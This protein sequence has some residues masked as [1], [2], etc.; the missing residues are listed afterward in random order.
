[1]SAVKEKSGAT[2]IPVRYRLE[3]VALRTFLSL[4]RL[5]P[6]RPGRLLAR[7]LG[8]LLYALGGRRRALALRNI[9]AAS[10]H[11]WSR[12]PRTVARAN[13]IHLAYNLFEF[14]RMGNRTEGFFRSRV[15]FVGEE[16]VREAFSKGRGVLFL[17]AHMGNWEMMGAAY[18]ALKG[19]IHV[20]ARPMQ[21]PLTDALIN[22]IRRSSGMEVIPSRGA[23]WRV[24]RALRRGEAVGVLLD[25]NTLRRE[26]VFVDFLGRP[27]ATNYGLAALA[28]KTGSPVLPVYSIRDGRGRH[29]VVFMPGIPTE[30]TDDAGRDILENTARYSA[31]IENMVSSCPAQW[32]WVH[33]RW[34][35]QPLNTAEVKR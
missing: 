18:A 20:V 7:M 29:R 27:A 3:Y 11:S 25:Q 35:N 28:R 12:T 16:H 10:R 33:N 17:T 13:F 34:K 6:E 9:A 22:G 2:A 30:K 15:R 32:F 4:M 24:S 1:M 8:M 19:P 21:N 31:A 5:M 14:A 26:A 23:A